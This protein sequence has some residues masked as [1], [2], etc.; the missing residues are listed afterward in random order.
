M[1]AIETRH[2]VAGWQYRL[3]GGDWVGH[4]NSDREARRLGRLA[5]ERSMEA[6]EVESEGDDGNE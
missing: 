5:R 3:L 4:E 6:P 2:S 1:N